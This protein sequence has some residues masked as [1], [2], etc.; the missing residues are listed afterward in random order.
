M[1]ITET[2]EIPYGKMG[3]VKDKYLERRDGMNI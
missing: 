1:K 2:K 3:T